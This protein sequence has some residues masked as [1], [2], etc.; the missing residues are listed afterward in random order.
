MFS[1]HKFPN[2]HPLNEKDLLSNIRKAGRRCECFIQLPDNPCY[3]VLYIS[4]SRP[5]TGTVMNLQKEAFFKHLS[6]PPSLKQGHALHLSGGRGIGVR[7]ASTSGG[8]V[9][10]Q[11][12]TQLSA[13]LSRL[14]G[15][16]MGVFGRKTLVRPFDFW[17]SL[18]YLLEDKREKEER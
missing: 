18:K 7:S 3:S 13:F 4:I 14:G 2:T 9:L 17:I 6:T 16:I 15:T 8:E 5:P 1:C 10:P 11:T 12:S